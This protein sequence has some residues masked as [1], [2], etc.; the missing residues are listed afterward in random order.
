M[1]TGWT[2]NR[3]NGLLLASVLLGVIARF[4]LATFGNNYDFESY[5]LV[6]KNLRQSF[7]PWETDRYNYG[8]IWGFCIQI[9]DSVAGGNEQVFRLLLI[10]FLTICD[11]V[12]MYAIFEF[13]YKKAAIIF[14]L[15]PISVII[16]GYH[17]QF[18]NFALALFMAALLIYQK[19]IIKNTLSNKIFLLVMLGFSLQI[20]HVLLLFVFWLAFREI[21]LKNLFGTLI[22]PLVVFLLG[23]LPFIST[24]RMSIQ[25]NVFE[26]KSFDNAPLI[27]IL[28]NLNLDLLSFKI[29]FFVITMLLIGFFARKTNLNFSFLLYT[30]CLVLFSSAVANQYLAIAAI[31]AAAL[32]NFGFMLY[33]FFGTIWLL[34]SADGLNWNIDIIELLNEPNYKFV[35]VT[36]FIGLFILILKKRLYPGIKQRNDRHYE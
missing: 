28:S 16:T 12:I 17:N 18:D 27:S 14:F 31:G 30:V 22:L 5:I 2:K 23:F 32:F 1:Q 9:F 15:N 6:A 10:T 36:L 8:P 7:T 19:N 3:F 29:E 33:F 11:L 25:K 20:K 26:Y 13:G 34:A 4:F 21:N 35:P 24:S